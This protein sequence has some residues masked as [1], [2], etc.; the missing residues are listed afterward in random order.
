MTDREREVVTGQG[1]E[2]TLGQSG[3]GLRMADDQLTADL[4]QTRP[5]LGREIAFGAGGKLFDYRVGG[6]V[7]QPDR[8]PVI[9]SKLI[10]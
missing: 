8:I 4:E 3:S 7:A 10:S 1:Q 5:L 9:R 6:A 2:H